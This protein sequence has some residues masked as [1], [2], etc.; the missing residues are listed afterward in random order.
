MSAMRRFGL[1]V[2]G[3][4]GATDSLVALGDELTDGKDRTGDTC[5]LQLSSRIARPSTAIGATSL[6][7]LIL[8]GR[9]HR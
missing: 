8:Y 5:R 3:A 2:A 1:A 7:L 6:R 4:F 9:S